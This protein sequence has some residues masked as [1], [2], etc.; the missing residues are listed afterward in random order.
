MLKICLASTSPY[1]KE[2]LSRLGLEFEAK[3]PLFD[4]DSA[5]L[6]MTGES[7]KT[8]AQTLARGKAQSLHHSD[9]ITI[10]SDQ[11]VCLD[12]LVLGKTP[13]K[14]L[15]RQQLLR[16]Q[17]RPH[18]LLTAVALGAGDKLIEFIDE[19]RLYMRPLTS[20]EI[21]LYLE[22]DAPYDCAGTYKIE[23]RGISLF[24]KIETEDFTAIQGLPLIK[25]T[26]ILR[27]QGVSI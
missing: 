15:A 27:E 18:T 12:D 13:N 4:E 9:Q 7:P 23:K 19:T 3:K 16:L 14:D 2:L 22:H 5:K 20:E 11:L 6:Q 8:I 25:L 24:Q 10:G 21:D 17:G 26:Q 1:R